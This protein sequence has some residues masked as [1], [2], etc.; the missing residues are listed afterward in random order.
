MKSRHRKPT[1][2]GRTVTVAVCALAV[3]A[4]L[5]VLGTSSVLADAA[6][7][8]LVH[9]TEP[10]VILRGEVVSSSLAD[11]LTTPCATEDSD[12]CVWLGG[13]N[14]LGRS[15]VVVAGNVYPL[16]QE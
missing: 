15:F 2:T 6:R 12:N 1:H 9:A 13:T 11:A 8:Q 7:A 3:G 4:S 5:G 14:G 10:S 16:G